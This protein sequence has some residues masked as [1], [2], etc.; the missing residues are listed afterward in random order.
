[1]DSLPEKQE[2]ASV[3]YDLNR[4]GDALIAHAKLKEQDIER[5]LARQKEKNILFG[6]AAKELGLI[7]DKDLKKV[8]SEQFGYSYIHDVND[9]F[10]KSLV[11]AHTPFSNTVESLR[12]LRE[13]LLIRWFNQGN[14]SLAI[15][16]VSKADGASEL[17]ANL[18]ILFS[19]L[20]KKTLLIDADLRQPSHQKLF[21]IERKV[22][23]AN[24]LANR[25]GKYEILREKLLPNLSILSAGTQAPNPQE[26]LNREAFPRLLSDL[27]HVYDIILIDTSP[28]DIGLDYL[29]VL[30]K[31]KA[32]IIVARK[33]KTMLADLKMLKAQL[34]TTK[35][36]VVG[37][38]FQDV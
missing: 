7:A 14:K 23:L 37:S 11:A 16:S 28:A 34:D 27:E 20:N 29:A 33:D 19:Q 1:M 30:S 32:A 17:L 12:S 24:I 25:Q 36:H 4:I 21:G 22:G 38:V 9:H 31:V 6:E 2:Q 26:L 35:A 8:L 5:V 15:A 10:H 18:A 13:Q 3:E